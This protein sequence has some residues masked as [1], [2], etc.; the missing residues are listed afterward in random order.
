VHELQ[1]VARWLTGKP[2]DDERFKIEIKRDNF[3]CNP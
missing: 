2:V 1:E 3:I